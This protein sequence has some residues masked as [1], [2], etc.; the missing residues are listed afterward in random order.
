[1][2]A[3]VEEERSH[4]TAQPVSSKEEEKMEASKDLQKLRMCYK[5]VE[6]KLRPREDVV[7]IEGK[8]ETSKEVEERV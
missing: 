6:V 8:E 5:R 3:N 4:V 2:W 1:M 7:Y